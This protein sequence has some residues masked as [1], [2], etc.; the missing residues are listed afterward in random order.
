[1]GKIKALFWAN[2]FKME[3]GEEVEGK[4]F[5][6]MVAHVNIFALRLPRLISTNYP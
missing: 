4:N 5:I 1:M 3:R 2:I 6:K